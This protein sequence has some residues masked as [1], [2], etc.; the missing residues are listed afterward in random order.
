MSKTAYQKWLR[1]TKLHKNR[2]ENSISQVL[3]KPQDTTVPT[4]ATLNNN[5]QDITY[6]HPPYILHQTPTWSTVHPNMAHTPNS[7]MHTAYGYMEVLAPTNLTALNHR[8]AKP[9]PISHQSVIDP[10]RH[11]TDLAHST[12][13]LHQQTMDAFKPLLNLWHDKLM[14]SS[15]MIY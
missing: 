4:S 13:H 10:L 9:T 14:Y 2:Q 12:Q 11:Q 1:P 7:T 3:A 8:F 5:T 6:A 15:L